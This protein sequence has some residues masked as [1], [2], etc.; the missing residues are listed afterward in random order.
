MDYYEN[1]MELRKAIN[2]IRDN[3][4]SPT[5]PGAFND[6]IN[7]LLYHDRYKA[8]ICGQFM[9]LLV[10]AK[11]RWSY[12]YMNLIDSKLT[13]VLIKFEIK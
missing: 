12:R 9:C 10:T 2:Q 4:F 1:S 8:C 7:S 3:Y 11:Q 6:I 5:E 13:L